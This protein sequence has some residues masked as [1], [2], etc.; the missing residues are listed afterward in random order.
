[1]VFVPPS[2]SYDANTNFSQFDATLFYAGEVPCIVFPHSNSDH[3]LLVAH[4]NAEDMWSSHYDCDVLRHTLKVHV[5]CFEYPG[6]G[7]YSKSPPSEASVHRA[8]DQ[9]F[10]ILLSW[11]IP[12]KQILVL[13]RSLGAAVACA[14][15]TRRAPG[16]LIMLSPF[17]S[18]REV[19]KQAL[20]RATAAGEDSLDRLWP[21]CLFL[22]RRS[23]M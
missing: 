11:G 5:V 8:A 23:A 7:L 20:D 6:Y 14:L 12:S 2:P 13:G 3:V 22:T 15:A 21:T 10:D 4:A 9:V 17:A 18:I 19:A 1:M 16:G